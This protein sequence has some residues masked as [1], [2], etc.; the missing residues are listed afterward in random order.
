MEAKRRPS[1]SPVARISQSS[2]ASWYLSTRR[3]PS[4]TTHSNLAP[5][6]ESAGTMGAREVH[7]STS[8]SIDPAR[9]R[10]LNSMA[11]MSEL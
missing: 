1:W 10:P 2:W 6:F 4:R 9:R 3:S 8:S 5:D 11:P 7:P